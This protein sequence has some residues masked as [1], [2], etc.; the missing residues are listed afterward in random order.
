MKPIN[1]LAILAA[2]SLVAN[3]ATVVVST[4]RGESGDQA[5]MLGQAGQTFTTGTL[6][7]DTLLSTIDLVGPATIAGA[8]PVGPFT[9]KIWTDIDGD[10]TTWDPGTEVA[11]ST[12]TVTIPAG[13]GT[14]T[15]L[16]NSGTLSDSTVYVMSFTS[17]ATNHASFRM[18]LTAPTTNG[19]LGTTGKLFHQGGN[20]TFGDN[21]ELAFTVT[22]I[23][24]PTSLALLGLGGL[25]LLRRR[26]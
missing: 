4:T 8:D 6:G 5:N 12:N 1:T 25:A 26:R 15:A 7:V 18:G 21:R 9:V 13:D 20:P 2:T 10:A 24:E 17:G 11:A 19:P 16:F 22:T 14:V 3:A 23:P